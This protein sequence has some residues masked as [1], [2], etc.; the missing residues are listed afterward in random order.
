MATMPTDI[1]VSGTVDVAGGNVAIVRPGDRLLVAF[2]ERG[3]DQEM[4]RI[5]VQLQRRLPDVDVAVVTGVQALAVM[6][7]DPEPIEPACAADTCCRT[8][9]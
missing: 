8:Q 9:P 5:K 7:A 3:T 4:E 2:R 1:T 6:P